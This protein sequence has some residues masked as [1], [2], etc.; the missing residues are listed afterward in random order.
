[1]L[2]ATGRQGLSARGLDRVFA[3]TGQHVARESVIDIA[4]KPVIGAGLGGGC[5]QEE[6]RGESNLLHGKR[7]LRSCKSW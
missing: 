3:F 2:E 4:A 6:G 5:G 1:M 7:K